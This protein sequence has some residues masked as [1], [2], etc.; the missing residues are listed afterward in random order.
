MKCKLT[1]ILALVSVVM[2]TAPAQAAFENL[3]VS[4]RAR[5]M[6][7]ASVADPSAAYAATLNPA[8]LALLQG[9]GEASASYVQPYG[10]DFHKLLY[11][12]AAFRLPGK[13][14]S[15]GIG[16][17]QYGVDYQDVSLQSESTLTVAYGLPLYTDIH[18]SISLG[19]GLN[20]YRLEFGE[21]VGQLDPGNDVS[22]GLDV[23]LRAT[24][25]GRTHVGVMV[26]NL[27]VPEIGRDQ[28]ELPR[29]MHGGIAYEPYPGV[30][31]VFELE[32][33]HGEDPQWRGGLE[34]AVLEGLVVRTGIMTEPSKLTGGFGYTF[35]GASLDYG[36]STGG[37]VL[38]SSHQFGLSWA[39]GGE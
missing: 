30:L 24:L 21:T 11:L 16:F 38:D 39:W 28:E 25:H 7:D 2:L 32:S 37:G 4:P 12:G 5:A 36:F 33:T 15:L 23:G 22:T 1:V 8:G 27:D 26:H 17:R 6:G 29:R 10:L 20:M 3:M 19:V 31:T 35:G 18:S 34:V 9:D 14:G 13:S